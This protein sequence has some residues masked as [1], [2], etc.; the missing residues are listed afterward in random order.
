M[1]NFEIRP[2]VF[3]GKRRNV[4]AI[5][6]SL[7]TELGRCW[8]VARPK[9]FELLTPRFVVWCSI[10]LSYGRILRARTYWGAFPKART[11]RTRMG[12]CRDT[13]RFPASIGGNV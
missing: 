13:P 1:R 10:Q 5:S 9:R 2:S 4:G 3:D 6:E 12:H 7:R 11:T 8:N